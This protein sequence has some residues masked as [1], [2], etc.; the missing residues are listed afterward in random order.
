[1]YGIFYILEIVSLSKEFNV[2][3]SF[4]FKSCQPKKLMG[5]QK[6]KYLSG[7]TSL[8]NGFLMKPMF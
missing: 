5:E 3:F 4:A 7:S 8:S 2:F 1:M 6:K